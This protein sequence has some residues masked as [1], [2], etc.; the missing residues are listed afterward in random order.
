MTDWGFDK[1][2]ESL[3]ALEALID[4]DFGKEV[5]KAVDRD[6]WGLL[7]LAVFANSWPLVTKICDRGSEKDYPMVN[8]ANDAGETAFGLAVRLSQTAAAKRIARHKEFRL[9]EQ[10]L[11]AP[12]PFGV[13]LS[14]DFHP[15]GPLWRLAAAKSIEEARVLANPLDLKMVVLARDF[16][17]QVINYHAVQAVLEKMR[18]DGQAVK[19]ENGHDLNIVSMGWNILQH[20][21][22]DQRGEVVRL[23]LQH[24]PAMNL[25]YDN[26]TA[27]GTVL[28]TAVQKGYGFAVEAILE[29]MEDDSLLGLAARVSGI[30]PREVARDQNN[31]AILKM[32]EDFDAAVSLA[33]ST[34]IA[35]CRK[36]VDGLKDGQKCSVCI[37]RGKNSGLPCG[38]VF[39]GGKN[40]FLAGVRVGGG[41]I[42]SLQWYAFHR[43]RV[44]HSCVCLQHDVDASRSARSFNPIDSQS[45]SSGFRPRKSVRT[46]KSRLQWDRCSS[47]SCDWCEAEG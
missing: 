26:G 8:K 21:V 7:H 40:F 23:L 36:V 33:K 35:E 28:H 10:N 5:L 6:G 2:T 32:I 19:G 15:C 29:R 43:N 41:G 45:A 13:V 11:G 30:T 25:A 16:G 44:P 9:S 4:S 27:S 3:V 42:E 17:F 37:D 18:G 31:P 22:F 12:G 39:C 1:L 46:A 34:N 24:K 14:I 20:A 38:H 47:C